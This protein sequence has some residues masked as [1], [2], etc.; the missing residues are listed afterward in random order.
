[1]PSTSRHRRQNRSNQ[2]ITLH[3]SGGDHALNKTIINTLPAWVLGRMVRSRCASR[4]TCTRQ[5]CNRVFGHSVLAAAWDAAHPV[6]GQH[7]RSGN[8]VEQGAVGGDRLVRAPAIADDFAGGAVHQHEQA[9]MMRD[10]RAVRHEH[11]PLQGWL[12]NQRLHLPAPGR[13]PTERTALLGVAAPATQPGDERFQLPESRGAC[14]GRDHA[15]VALG[16]F[17]ALRARSGPA[18]LLHPPAAQ[19]AALRLPGT[20]S[21]PVQRYPA[22][23]LFSRGKNNTPTRLHPQSQTP[24]ISTT[25]VPI[26]HRRIPGYDCGTEEQCC[27]TTKSVFFL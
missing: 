17:P 8:A 2:A 22:D 13:M 20:S 21:H 27:G 14:A 3:K 1:M 16:A 15:R 12:R 26:T 23:P 19:R 7:V 4:C 10:I 9:V 5:R 11:V 18:V 6:A 24:I 25:K